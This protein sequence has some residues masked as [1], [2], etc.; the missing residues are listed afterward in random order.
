MGWVIDTIPSPIYP[1]ERHVT[2][3]VGCRMGLPPRACLDGRGI[4]RPNWD[5]N[6]EPYQLGACRYTVNAI[7]LLVRNKHLCV[8]F[9]TACLSKRTLCYN[10]NTGRGID[11]QFYL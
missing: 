4:S 9:T 10:D 5:S 8:L 1:R 11:P 3:N 2:H 6:N 7:P